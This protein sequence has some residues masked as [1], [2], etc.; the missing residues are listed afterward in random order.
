M[1]AQSLAGT[2]PT[3]PVTP[4]AD[5]FYRAAFSI[6]GYKDQLKTWYMNQQKYIASPQ[7]EPVSL[8]AGSTKSVSD[9]GFTDTDASG[10]FSWCPFISFAADY[11]SSE[12]RQSLDVSNTQYKID[13]A[14]TYGDIQAFDILPGTW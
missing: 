13:L 5:I 10:S 4:D 3:V 14:L 8:D 11:H 6:Q 12:N 9:F 1:Y 2:T 7:K